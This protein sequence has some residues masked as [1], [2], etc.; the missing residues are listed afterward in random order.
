MNWI[1]LRI[2]LREHFGNN[3]NF[4]NDKYRSGKRRIKIR[5]SNPNSILAYI[6]QIAPELDAKLYTGYSVTIHYNN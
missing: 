4:Y 2:K 3:F 1:S 6:K 5:T